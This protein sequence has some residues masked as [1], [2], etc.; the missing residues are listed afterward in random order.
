MHLPACNTDESAPC[1][2][3]VQQWTDVVQ[4]PL[5][6]QRIYYRYSGRVLLSCW[7]RLDVMKLEDCIT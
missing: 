7:N 6:L 3:F 5:M 4:A 2:E 1:A